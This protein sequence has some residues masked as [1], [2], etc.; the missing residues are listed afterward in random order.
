M[1]MGRTESSAPG[2]PVRALRHGVR[3]RLL[4][5]FASRCKRCVGTHGDTRRDWRHIHAQFMGTQTTAT[6]HT[7]THMGTHIHKHMHKHTHKHTHKQARAHTHTSCA[8]WLWLWLAVR[9]CGCWLIFAFISWCP[10]VSW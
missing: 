7:H 2:L 5:C 9:G 6:Q 10:T 1:G 3:S 8:S 4:V